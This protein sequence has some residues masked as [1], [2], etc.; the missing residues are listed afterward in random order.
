MTC[1]CH[2]PGDTGPEPYE[3]E[4]DRLRR[5]GICP[6]CHGLLRVSSADPRA[7]LCEDEAPTDGMEDE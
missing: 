7:C 2:N 5:G 3:T 1:T 4:Y 6:R